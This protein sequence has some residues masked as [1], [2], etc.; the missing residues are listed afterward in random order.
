[1][2]LWIDIVES[3]GKVACLLRRFIQGD[4]AVQHKSFWAQLKYHP[5]KL[6]LCHGIQ[7]SIS[8]GYSALKFTEHRDAFALQTKTSQCAWK[9]SKLELSQTKFPVASEKNPGPMI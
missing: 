3:D 1:M 6:A 8:R 5:T 4:I 9:K 7:T 2:A